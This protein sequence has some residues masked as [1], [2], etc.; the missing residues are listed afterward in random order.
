MRS[1]LTAWISAACFRSA[2]KVAGSI[3]NPSTVANRIARSIRSRSSLNRLAGSPIARTT[4][5]SRSARPPTKSM[6]SPS[7]GSKNIPL[8]V[9]SRLSASSRGEEK[10]TASG[11]RPSMY[12]PSDRNVATS[13]CRPSSITQIT[14][15]CAPTATVFRKSRCTSSGRALVAMS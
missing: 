1:A 14:P 3:S 8:I 10:V 15:K 9:K 6:T 2:A 7:I 12:A 4:R 11:C 13:N 5:R